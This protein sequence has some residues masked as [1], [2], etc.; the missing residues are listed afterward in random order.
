MHGSM[1]VK[2]TI[3]DSGHRNNTACPA[4]LRHRFRILCRWF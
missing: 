3:F 4:N 2:F 1:N